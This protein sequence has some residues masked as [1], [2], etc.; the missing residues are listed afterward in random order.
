[1]WA[2]CVVEKHETTDTSSKI[3]LG[4]VFGTIEFFLLQNAEEFF[5]NGIVIWGSASGEGLGHAFFLQMITK[6]SGD[7]GDIVGALIGMKNERIIRFAC[8]IGIVESPFGERRVILIGDMK[9]DYFSGI[10]IHDDAEE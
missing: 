8:A 9:S 2:F 4:C 3:L 5:T 1:M 6:C 10:Q 7:S